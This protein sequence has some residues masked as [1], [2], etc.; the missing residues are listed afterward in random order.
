MTNETT[1]QQKS[2]HG[3]DTWN[4]P[5]MGATLALTVVLIATAMMASAFLGPEASSP[6]TMVEPY[7]LKGDANIPWLP[8]GMYSA[9][10][11]LAALVIWRDVA[12]AG[13]GRRDA[14]G[15]RGVKQKGAVETLL[16]VA[17]GVLFILAANALYALAAGLETATGGIPTKPIR[18]V[19]IEDRS[20]PMAWCN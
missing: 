1:I 5:G 9:G 20:C 2:G 18:P 11:T 7:S 14:I 12:R 4:I 17:G 3:H 10:L 15:W 8:L 16:L 19:S 13:A 6:S